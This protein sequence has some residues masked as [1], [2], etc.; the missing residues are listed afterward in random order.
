MPASKFCAVVAV[1]VLVALPVRLPVTFPM[2]LPVTFPVTVPVTFPMTF[3]DIVP[4][5]KFP[6]PSRR[7]IVDGDAKLVAVVFALGTI[8]V[9]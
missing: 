6:E 2:T 8:P 1:P 3:A 5:A 9:S 7:T 4:A